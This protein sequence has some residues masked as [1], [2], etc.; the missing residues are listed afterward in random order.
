[1]GLPLEGYRQKNLAKHISYVPQNDGRFL[2][3]TVEE[4]LMM[5]RYPHLS[6][7]TSISEED[8]LAVHDALSATGTTNL[9]QRLFQTLSGGEQQIVSIAATLVQGSS[10]VLLDE[11]TTFLDP[12]H[13]ADVHSILRKVNRQMGKTVVTVT[14]D[15]NSAALNSDRII[16][17]KNGRIEFAG[18]PIDVMNNDILARIYEKPFTFV[19]HPESEHLIIAP[20]VPD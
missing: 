19:K 14:H 5:G 1:M 12:K 10:I 2:P 15:I 20:E 4:F 6:P 13:E 8:K 7:F 18:N 17:L 9:A 11:P 16:I 3:F